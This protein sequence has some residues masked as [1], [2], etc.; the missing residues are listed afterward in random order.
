MKTQYDESRHKN[1]QKNITVESRSKKLD[2]YAKRTN[3]APDTQTAVLD[4]TLQRRVI[5]KIE[6][7]LS[8][9]QFKW[10]RWLFMQYG[11]V[12]PGWLRRKFKLNQRRKKLL[13]DILREAQLD[14]VMCAQARG[15]EDWVCILHSVWHEVNGVELCR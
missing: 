7:K 1:L 3:Y 15:D 4:P 8:T 2:K 13:N 12:K 14:K 5:N 11:Q 6:I 9:E 10:I